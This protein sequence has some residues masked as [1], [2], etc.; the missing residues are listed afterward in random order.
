MLFSLPPLP[1]ILQQRL[2]KNFRSSLCWQDFTVVS[3]PYL[4]SAP[5]CSV[6]LVLLFCFV[7][8]YYRIFLLWSHCF[9]CVIVI[10]APFPTS[11]SLH[12]KSVLEFSISS[13]NTRLTC[14]LVAIRVLLIG[15]TSVEIMQMYSSSQ[16]SLKRTAL[17]TDCVCRHSFL[18][19]PACSLL[20]VCLLPA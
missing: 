20:P 11:D 14:P 1:Q 2:W 13:H 9:G 6:L 5:W 10:P 4:F 7:I 16:Q 18:V 8:L 15:V 17:S 3:L 12:S 19:I